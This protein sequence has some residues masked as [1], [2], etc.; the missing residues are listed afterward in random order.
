MQVWTGTKPNQ[1]FEVQYYKLENTEIFII[2]KQ[3]NIYIKI[4]T[5]KIM[6]SASGEMACSADQSGSKESAA[7]V[8]MDLATR[9]PPLLLPLPFPAE[10]E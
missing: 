10:K 4:E 9:K 5:E 2:K 6:T 3:G 8:R 1:L 7:L